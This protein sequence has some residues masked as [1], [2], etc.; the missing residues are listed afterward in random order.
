[1]RKPYQ[2]NWE[3]GE[4]LALVA[5]RREGHIAIIDQVDG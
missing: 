1:M 3:H 4:I 2:P 5:A